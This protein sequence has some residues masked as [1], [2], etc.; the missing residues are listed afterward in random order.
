MESW[1]KLWFPVILNSLLEGLKNLS[2]LVECVHWKL[3][4]LWGQQSFA[5]WAIWGESK[6]MSA[7]FAASR[8]ALA[9]A[10][11]CN[12]KRKD[13]FPISYVLSF[14]SPF[15]SLGTWRGTMESE[16]VT[17]LNC[18]WSCSWGG[19]LSFVPSLSLVLGK[20]LGDQC[21]HFTS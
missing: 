19:P 9:G 11:C 20:V 15:D 4:C 17:V 16:S 2:L 10:Y 1:R 5:V 14:Q 21:L 8:T 18:I 6:A 3:R 7:V 13:H 12:L